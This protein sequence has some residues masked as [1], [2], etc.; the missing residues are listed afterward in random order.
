MKTKR[1]HAL[2]VELSLANAF[3]SVCMCGHLVD[4]LGN[5]GLVF[6]C[7]F[8]CCT[9]VSSFDVEAQI[10]KKP[11]SFLSQPDFIF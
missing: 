2:P 6:A 3:Q 7:A 1:S 5:Y 8:V 11:A 10:H 9:G 4:D